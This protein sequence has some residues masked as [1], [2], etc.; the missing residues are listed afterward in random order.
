MAGNLRLVGRGVITRKRFAEVTTSELS[1]SRPW[2]GH[3]GKTIA[4]G[5]FLGFD[6]YN[7][8]LQ[9]VKDGDGVVEVPLA[10]F[11]RDDLALICNG[12]CT[13]TPSI[14]LCLAF[15]YSGS[16]IPVTWMTTSL[17]MDFSRS[18]ERLS[19]P[20]RR[21]LIPSYRQQASFRKLLNLVWNRCSMPL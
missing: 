4:V 5:T 6:T 20:L 14:F 3:D 7:A 11:R 9:A 19:F 15:N 18:T 12:R 1:T 16:P 2:R 17:T 8:A 10:D 13:G 21:V